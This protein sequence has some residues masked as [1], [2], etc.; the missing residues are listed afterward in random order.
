VIRPF[1]LRDLFHIRQFDLPK[2]AFDVRRLLLYAPSAT[3]A[4]VLGY[5]TRHHLGAV[6]Y[7]QQ[8]SDRGGLEGFLEAWPRGD[9]PEWDLAFLAPPLD[10]GGVDKIWRQLL[11]S[12]I[13]VAAD[14]NVSRIY[15]RA[16]EDVQ[17]EQILHQV[18]FTFVKRE[19]VFALTSSTSFVPPVEGLRKVRTEDRR[20]LSALCR[21]AQPHL[22]KR[23][24]G[25]P[26]HGLLDFYPHLQLGAVTKEYMLMQEDTPVAYFGLQGSCRGYWLDIVRDPDDRS[27]LSPCV[28]HVLGTTQGT[29]NMP[30]YCPVPDYASGVTP[31]L[32]ELG[33][34]SY[35]RQVVLVAHTISRV[36][37]KSEIPVGALERGLDMGR[38]VG[39]MFETSIQETK[40]NK[41]C[42][43]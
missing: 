43:V 21:R 28:E 24:E 36:P 7:V 17:V 38:P 23:A 2:T 35:T 20:L 32:R 5:L 9:R 6:T 30:V 26:P 39:Q 16:P 12:L 27:D 29:E 13:A 37:V 1:G 41:I 8:G 18:G 25:I 33:F 34:T 42:D 22:G 40:E 14:K 19:E 11:S 10:D 3:G 15:A 4:A 31:L